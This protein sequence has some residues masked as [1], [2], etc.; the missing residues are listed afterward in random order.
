MTVADNTQKTVIE[1]ILAAMAEPQIAGAPYM[2]TL[3]DAV[4]GKGIKGV[5]AVSV[6]IAAAQ[7]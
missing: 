3:Y 5:T 1:A 7:A 6:A 2:I 4:T